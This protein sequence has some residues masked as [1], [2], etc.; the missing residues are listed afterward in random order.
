M[1]NLGTYR[2]KMTM[3]ADQCKSELIKRKQTWKW[4]P[5]EKEYV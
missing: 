3:N 5:V 2:L 4:G 1:Q